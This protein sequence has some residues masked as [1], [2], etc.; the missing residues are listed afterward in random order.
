MLTLLLWLAG[1]AGLALQ[2]QLPAPSG[3]GGKQPIP[4]TEYAGTEACRGCHK[5]KVETFVK[6]AH[7][8]D[9]RP[10]DKTS[11][12]GDFTPG[13]NRLHTR[14]PDLHY[15]ME[16]RP[17]GLYVTAT[18]GAGPARQTRSERIDI[19][20]GS[21]RKGQSYL[22]WRGSEL[23]QLPV[24]LWAAE[25]V[26]VNSPGYTDGV[27]NFDRPILPRC[28]ECHATSFEPR[29]GTMNTYNPASV[30]LGIQCEKC[31]GPGR[32]HIARHS[33][34]P[35]RPADIVNTGKLSRDRQVDLCATCHAG[36]IR[37][38]APA[39][40]YRPGEP[41]GDY[42]EPVPPINPA[43]AAEVHG[44]QVG[45]LKAS[46]CYQQSPSMTCSTCHD[47][48]VP[49]R[50]PATFAVQC[51]TCHKVEACKLFPT[52]GRRI[53]TRCVDCHMPNQRSGVISVTATAMQMV[54]DVR[55]H[56]IKGYPE[57]TASVLK[58]LAR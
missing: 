52:A 27:A 58:T 15:T 1:L 34:M 48:H 57:A 26:W 9:S 32:A 20:T 36:G 29:A 24:S 50:D 38:I 49:Q 3:S 35:T 5:E 39:F 43:A 23:F 12:L 44:N 22:Y 25:R 53:E 28:L 11:V 14:N 47:V 18:T 6:T 40:S 7:Y 46:A 30:I 55:T 10:G 45:L 33:P 19:V 31:H 16:E 2:S 17:H 41:L 54:P 8:L 13:R 4:S 56:W 37:P 21:G 42:F 51:R